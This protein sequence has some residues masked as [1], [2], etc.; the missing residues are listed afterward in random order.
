MFVTASV[1]QEA[2]ILR[3]RPYGDVD[4]IVTFLTHG[5]GKLTGIAKGAKHSRRRFANCL[6]PLARVRMHYRVRP[7]PG[8]VFLERCDLRRPGTVYS[9]PRRLAY[10]SYLAELVDLLTEEAHAVPEMFTLLDEAL[11]LLVEGPASGP[12]LRAFEMQL[13]VAAGYG[14]RF[15]VCSRC[16]GSLLGAAKACLEAD[17]SRVFCATCAPISGTPNSVLQLHGTTAVTLEDLKRVPLKVAQNLSFEGPTAAEASIAL[18]AL[19]APHLRRPLRS[20]AVL[21]QLGSP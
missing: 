11:A 10:G 20:L 18:S 1:S 14:P 17:H 6:D 21:R 4:A 19:L 12:F 2:V 15:D 9:E 5:A 8:L 13:L 3:T 16:H 7:Q